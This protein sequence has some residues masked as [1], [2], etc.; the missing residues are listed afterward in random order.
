M[1]NRSLNNKYNDVRVVYVQLP[2]SAGNVTLLAFAAERRPCSN[3]LAG[4]PTAA[5]PP[6]R[7]VAAGRWDGRTRTDRRTLGSFIDPAAHTVQEQRSRVTVV[8]CADK[9][10]DEWRRSWFSSPDVARS[11]HGGLAQH[12]AIHYL[13]RRTGQSTSVGSTHETA[14]IQQTSDTNG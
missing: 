4:G 1:T 11:L 9:C 2:T 6:Q 3:L 7:R 5:N 13:S 12:H 14:A 8:C 10:A